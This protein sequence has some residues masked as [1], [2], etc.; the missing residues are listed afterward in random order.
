MTMQ[1]TTNLA[2]TSVNNLTLKEYLG[3]GW[4]DHFFKEQTIKEILHASGID[5][6]TFVKVEKIY[7]SDD[8]RLSK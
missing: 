1:S 3:A 5:D 7:A 6:Q 2:T 8:D 4:R